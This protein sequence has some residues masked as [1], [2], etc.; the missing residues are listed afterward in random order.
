MLAPR[1]G[2]APPPTGNLGSTPDSYTFMCSYSYLPTVQH[3][4]ILNINTK[5]F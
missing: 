5:I 1:G 2:L 3:I 4:A